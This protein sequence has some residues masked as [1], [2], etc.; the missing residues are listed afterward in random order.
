MS[1]DRWL[2]LPEGLF[3]G[4]PAPENPNGPGAQDNYDPETGSMKWDTLDTA[5]LVQQRNEQTV[6]GNVGAFVVPLAAVGG[7]VQRRAF[8]QS[9]AQD[10]YDVPDEYRGIFDLHYDEYK[11]KKK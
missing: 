5:G 6:S 2:P 8:P 1:C 9:G 10:D 11:P 4:E 3:T 7:G